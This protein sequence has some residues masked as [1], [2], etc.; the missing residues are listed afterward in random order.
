VVSGRLRAALQPRYN[1]A[2]GLR[3]HFGGFVRQSGVRKS[4]QVRAAASLEF[5][6]YNCA[7]SPCAGRH[8]FQCRAPEKI[9][10]PKD[11]GEDPSARGVSSSATDEREKH[12]RPM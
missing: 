6:S 10:E 5:R 7:T 4:L 1:G 11:R 9:K 2:A 8:L 12:P 3:V